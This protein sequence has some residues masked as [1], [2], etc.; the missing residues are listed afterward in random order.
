IGLELL[1]G[2]LAGHRAAR[3]LAGPGVGARA[4]PA[5]GQT[6]DM[7]KSAIGLDLL[8]PLDVLHHLAAELAFD[9]VLSLDELVD[10]R[11]LL[12]GELFRALAPVDLG[13]REELLRDV[14]PD[15]VDVRERHVETLVRGDVHSADTGHVF[16][17]ALALLVTLVLADHPH[18]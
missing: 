5:D 18:H 2:L 11:D 17:S 7:P 14:R 15:A 4:L 8:E 9:H 13:L 10:L 16:T 1:H 6:L 12:F 3:A